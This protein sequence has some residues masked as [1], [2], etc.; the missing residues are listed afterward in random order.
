MFGTLFGHF[1]DTFLTLFDHLLDTFWILF[2]HILDF[3]WDMFW[4][5]LGDVWDLFLVCL[6]VNFA[7]NA[8]SQN[9]KQSLW[10]RQPIKNKASGVVDFAKYTLW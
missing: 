1:L 6:E 10:E 8:S 2:V 5:C 3:C 7:K 4:R 9:P